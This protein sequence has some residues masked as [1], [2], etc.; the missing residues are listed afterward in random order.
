VNTRDDDI[1]FDFFEE[2]ATQEAPARERGPAGPRGPSGGRPVLRGPGGITPLLRLVGLVAF[3]IFIVVLLVFWVQSC[4]SDKKRESYEDYMSEVNTIAKDSENVGREFANLLTTPGLKLTDLQTRMN[5]LVDQQ[6]IDVNKAIAL[7]PPG[8]LRAA[9]DSA[10]EALQFRVSGLRGLADAFDSTKDSKEA[11]A[12]GLL[13]AQQADRLV[14]SDVVWDDLFRARAVRELKNQDITGV[15]V[16]DS[17]FVQT[18]DLASQRSMTQV[19]QRIQGAATGG[20]PTGLHGTGLGVVKALPSG[21]QLVPGVETTIEASTELAFEA[22]VQNTG[23]GQE[24]GVQVKLTI[25]RAANPIVKTQTI[26]II[27]PGETKTVTFSDF[28]AVPF[29]EKVNL[30]VDIAPVPGETNRKNNSAEYP[31]FFS[32]V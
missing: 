15:N 1:D 19:W 2:P 5:G 20:T 25:P 17:N 24:V 32:A 8:P 16:P 21:K 11:A 3:A 26:D 18:T 6:D 13:L 10:V 30:R 28:P 4:Q 31:V 12:A 27:E 29:G 22:A 7:D 14:A 23:Q 9:H